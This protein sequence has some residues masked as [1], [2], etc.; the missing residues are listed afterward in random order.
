MEKLQ[1]H[2]DQLLRATSTF[3]HRYLFH[4]I[5]W[6]NRMIGIV[7]PRGV[8]KTTLVLQHIKE[9][10]D[11]NTSLYMSLP[12]TFIFPHIVSWI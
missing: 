1:L 2:F 10:L 12:K 7:G 6:D 8:G 3:F 4:E 5:N 11:R 9:E